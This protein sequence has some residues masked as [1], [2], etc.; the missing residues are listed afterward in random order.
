M[1]AVT[2]RS[3]VEGRKFVRRRRRRFRVNSFVTNTLSLFVTAQIEG[4]KRERR[5]GEDERGGG[6][7]LGHFKFNMELTAAA[8][9]AKIEIVPRRRAAAKKEPVTPTMA[10][11]VL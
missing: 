2:T 9:A 1:A 8:S 7:N 3:Q 4:R 11:V 5:R 10:A 6:S